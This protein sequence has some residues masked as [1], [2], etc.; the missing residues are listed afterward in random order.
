MP[1]AC[2]SSA[3]FRKKNSGCVDDEVKGAVIETV[4]RMDLCDSKFFFF[5]FSFQVICLSMQ[6]AM[7]I[8]P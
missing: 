8:S 6:R 7:R 2:G 4:D 3:R 5:S 1:K